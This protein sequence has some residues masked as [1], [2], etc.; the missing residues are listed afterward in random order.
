MNK[1]AI[2][3]LNWNG[4]DLMPRCLDSLM[5]QTYKN[6]QIIVVDNQSKDNSKEI[7]T[8]YQ[9]KLEDKLHIIYNDRNSGF[10]GGVNIGIRY[11]LEN[12]FDGIAL[13][14]NDATPDKNWLSNLARTLDEKEDVGI[15]TSLILHEDGKT[16]DSTGDWYTKWGLSS[17]LYRDEGVE[18]TP[19]SDY[20]FAA[21]GGASLYRASIFKDIGLFDETFFA[22]YEDIDLS[23]RTQLAGYK[24][25]YEKSAVV[26]HEQGGTSKK[27]P[28]FGVYVTFKNLPILFTK[29]VPRKLLLKIGSRFFVAYWLIFFN[30]IPHGTVLYAL[31][32]WLASL[33]YTPHAIL[34]RMKIQKNKRVS[35]E[36]IDSIIYQD[37]PPLQSGLRK[38]R[39]I[40]IGGDK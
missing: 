12:G 28:G 18:K 24:V 38:F 19:E 35:A 8:T 31:K 15:V 9:K 1:L 25:Y 22:Y 32:G 40:F 7:L 30:T 39:S 34:E 13:F 20:V 23:F 5:E 14:N 6:F 11:A 21:S 27:I 17:P 26:Y 36:Y 29:N 4:A 33:Y 16:I 2:V 3:V 10:A 37:L